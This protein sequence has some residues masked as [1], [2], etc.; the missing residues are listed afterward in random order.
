MTSGRAPGWRP[1]DVEVIRQVQGRQ[2]RGGARGSAL[3]VVVGATAFLLGVGGTLAARSLLRGAGVS[4]ADARRVD[5]V[6][7]L[8][9]AALVWLGPVSAAQVAGA[10]LPGVRTV[11]LPCTGDGRPSCGGLADG[12]LDGGRRL[13]GLRRALRLPEGPLVLAAFSAGGHIVR[14]LCADARDRA[15]IAAVLLCDATYST[16]RDAAGRVQP[17][18]E[19]VAY[20]REA[21]GGARLLVATASTSPN[22]TYPTGQQTLEAIR[23]AIAAGEAG[24]ARAPAGVPAP[25]WTWR[26]GGVVLLGYGGRHTHAAHATALARPL[27]EHII[28]PRFGGQERNEA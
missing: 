13:P 25:E 19:I 7:A 11:H 6:P 26:R 8:A 5:A 3:E 4:A 1:G 17:L 21:L 15:E 2:G 20:G 28:R 9:P 27:V 10:D 22:K 12:W 24:E 16:T 14:R 23:D 18:P